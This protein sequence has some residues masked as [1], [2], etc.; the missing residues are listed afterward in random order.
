MNYSQLLE[1]AKDLETQ[2]SQLRFMAEM[3]H[4]KTRK[5]D[6]RSWIGYTFRSSSGLTEE[7]AEFSKAIKK[8]LKK[9][10]GYDLVSYSRGHFFFSA[11]LKNTT[12]GKL[13]YISSSDVR[14]FK[15][16]W[17]NRL[18]IRTAQHD[19]DF[20]GGANYMTLFSKIKEHADKLTK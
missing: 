9:I 6:I 20:T 12:T 18:L 3:E 16:E 4:K 10:D 5:K 1:K 19:K 17:Y 14:F 2:A 15:D 13:V 7:W 8:E 11:F